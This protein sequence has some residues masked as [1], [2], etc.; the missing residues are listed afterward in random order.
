M[1]MTAEAYLSQLQALLPTG[2]AWPRGTDAILTRLLASF[3]AEL[4]RID[5]RSEK[6]LSESLPS[7]AYELLS[8]WEGDVGLPD[9]CSTELAS[10]VE[11]RRQNVVSRLTM[12]GGA[13][14]AWFIAYAAAL[15]YTI[16]IDEFRPFV[17]GLSRCGDVLNG[18]HSVRHQWR[19][20]VPG[21]RY[22]AFR[23]GI[24]QCG[25]SLGKLTRADDLECRFRRLKP[26]HTTLIVSY[27]GA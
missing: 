25:D 18:G 6:L 26:A 8:E 22:T 24:S 2:L 11:E 9:A 5:A 14:R 15:G 12:R 20:N 4:A 16:T 3:A 17:S 23:T 1:A 7:S 13:S 19:V 27:K 21:P 10:T